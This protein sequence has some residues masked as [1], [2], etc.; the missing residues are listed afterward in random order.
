MS[1]KVNRS[2]QKKMGPG[3]G[4]SIKAKWK[5][6]IKIIFLYLM[7][8]NYSWCTGLKGKS[9]LVSTGFEC[10]IMFLFLN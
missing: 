8:Q 4:L 9:I 1:L 10:T 7:F 6:G 3:V 5:I 2:I